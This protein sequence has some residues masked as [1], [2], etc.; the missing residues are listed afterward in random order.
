MENINKNLLSGVQHIGIPTIDLNKTVEF[1]QKLG[2][3]ITFEA[4]NVKFMKIGN[5]VIEFYVVEKTNDFY[6]AIDH[7]AIDV[8]DIEE[9]YR[10]ICRLNYNTLDDE[11]HFL[12]F[13]EKG[14]KY[15][16]IEGPNKER[17]EFS[18]FLS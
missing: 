3:Y 11:I 8:I 10:E 7:I 13:W 16:T 2:F 12:P 1:Y 4:S 5:L 15:F 18:Q 14:V 17:L 6:G 9:V